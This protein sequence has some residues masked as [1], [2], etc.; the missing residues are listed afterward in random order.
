LSG[1]ASAA[2]LLFLGRRGK[3]LTQKSQREE[4]RGHGEVGIRLDVA[5]IPPLRAAE[6]RLSGPF[7]AQG[8]RDDS[9]AR[10]TAFAGAFAVARSRGR[11]TV[12]REYRYLT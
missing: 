3:E 2:P 7:E 11:P 9:V 8:K 10:W 4:H 6:A 12:R 5:L 1:V